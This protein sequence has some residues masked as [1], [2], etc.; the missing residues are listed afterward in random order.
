MTKA[1]KN[2]L[3]SRNEDENHTKIAC[4][5]DKS[6]ISLQRKFADKFVFVANEV[7]R[8]PPTFQD[9]SKVANNIL[10]SGFTHGRIIFNKFKSV[11]S[12]SCDS[13][14]IFSANALESAQNIAAYDSIDPE[15]LKDY[16]EYSLA[17]LIYYTMKESAC[18]EQSSRMTAMDN[19]SKNADDVIDELTM[20][21]H[22]TRQ[23]VITRELIDIVNMP[24]PSSMNVFNLFEY[25][26]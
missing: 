13:V 2:D 14:P 9:A 15:V 3:N 4:I 5:G 23:A 8:T 11:V 21:Y 26:K 20:K 12:Y 25:K 24:L 1:I 18:A 10:E 6:R 16:M 17:S 19:A 7:G 22:R